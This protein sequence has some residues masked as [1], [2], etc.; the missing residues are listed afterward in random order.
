MT[1]TPKEIKALVKTLRA[2]GVLQFK[3]PDIE[4]SLAP[5]IVPELVKEPVA[6]PIPLDTSA[7]EEKPI[8]HK[9]V[10]LTSLL[11]L[12]DKDLVDRLF[13]DY[14]DYGDDEAPVTAEAG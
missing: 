11:K 6:R 2:A 9:V 14:T 7:E 1:L 4:L 10:E 12:S 8:E 3:T 5:I 13:P